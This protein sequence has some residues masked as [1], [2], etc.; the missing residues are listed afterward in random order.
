ML[1]IRTSKLIE[2]YVNTFLHGLVSQYTL[3]IDFVEAMKIQTPTGQH[4]LHKAIS[5]SRFCLRDR[6]T[7]LEA[8]M[9]RDT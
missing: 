2:A 5:L 8:G 4:T 6:T 9:T 7:F 1:Q 3:P